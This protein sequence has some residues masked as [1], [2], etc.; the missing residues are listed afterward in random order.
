LKSARRRIE[1]LSAVYINAKPNHEDWQENVNKK[2]KEIPTTLHNSLVK[3][4]QKVVAKWLIKF[5]VFYVENGF[6]FLW[7]CGFYFFFLKISFGY[8]NC[9]WR[10]FESLGTLCDFIDWIIWNW[11]ILRWRSVGWC[12]NLVCFVAFILIWVAHI[13]W[14]SFL[15]SERYVSRSFG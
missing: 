11:V 7:I 12:M 15:I 6:C 2:C 8:L 3:H 5:I 14:I 9:P 13:F 1:K 10:A 4:S